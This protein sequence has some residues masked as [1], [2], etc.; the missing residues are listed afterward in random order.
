[1]Q[2]VSMV[3]KG[4]FHH[5]LIRAFTPTLSALE[6]KHPLLATDLSV[7]PCD[8]DSV[9]EVE[10]LTMQIVESLIRQKGKPEKQSPSLLWTGQRM[11]F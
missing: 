2:R 10:P 5:R 6:W 11:T 7:G 9:S 1:M 3:H 4:S 8:A